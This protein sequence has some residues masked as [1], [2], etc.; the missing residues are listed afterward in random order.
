L[1]GLRCAVVIAALTLP[2]TVGAEALLVKGMGRLVGWPVATA[3]GQIRFRDCGG[4]LRDM[5]DGRLTRTDKRCG[6]RQPVALSG[7][8]AGIDRARSLLVIETDDGQRR[9]FLVAR[10]AAG[11]LAD[12]SVGRRVQVEG[13]V[14]GHASRVTAQ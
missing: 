6:Q 9:P 2:T 1:S 3:D 8:V 13:P 12:L 7:V 5:G 4:T 14:P 10:P 11:A